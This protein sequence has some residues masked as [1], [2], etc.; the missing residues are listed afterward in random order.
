MNA[1][2]DLL[3]FREEVR[4]W[5]RSE[6]RLLDPDEDPRQG[7]TSDPLDRFSRARFLQRK[8]FEGG[9]AGLSFPTASGGA[10]MSPAFQQVLNEES[11]RYEMPVRFFMPTLGIIAPT[12]LDF[13]TKSQIERYIPP[14]LRGEALWVQFLSEPGCGSDLAG[15]RTSA[16]RD[17][18]LWMLNGAKTW[19]SAA[20]GCEYALCLARTN[21]NVPKH[22]GL[23][24]F[25]LDLSSPGIDLRQIR[26]ADGNQEFCEEF[27]TDVAVDQSAVLGEVDQGWAVASRLLSHERDSVGGG[28]PYIG[29]VTAWFR[30]AGATLRPQ[31]ADAPLELIVTDYVM[32]TVGHHLVERSQAATTPMGPL[33]RLYQ[34]GRSVQRAS[35]ALE[36]DGIDAVIWDDGDRGGEPA[37]QFLVRQANCLAGGSSE[38]QRNLISERLLGMPREPT[39]DHG[40]PFSEVL[41]AAKKRK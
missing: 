19:S 20:Y 2:E 34:A 1:T 16:V 5:L 31:S 17:G 33:L 11:V 25:I 30:G 32:A 13:G 39:P 40:V 41:A 14:M 3:T 12:I 27:L 10:G 23:T 4:R 6:M 38:M 18:D 24:M 29:D 36:L 35:A 8:V 7:M 21:W 28:S 26:Q 15:A 37:R 22:K 9:Y